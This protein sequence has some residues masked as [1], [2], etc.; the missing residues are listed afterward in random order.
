MILSQLSPAYVLCTLALLCGLTRA[1][2]SAFIPPQV[3][4][5]TIRV[6]TAKALNQFPGK[7]FFPIDIDPAFVL[8][9]EFV[10]DC[11]VL[12]KKA[13]DQAHLGFHSVAETFGDP[14]GEVNGRTYTVD[15]TKMVIN[16]K[17]RYNIRKALGAEKEQEPKKD[18]KP[19]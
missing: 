7:T 12:E 3:S 16:G 15:V 9:V 13:G 18:P 14:F 10:D 8:T 11:K 2:E 19:E 4:R 5:C 17:V 6:V 1:E